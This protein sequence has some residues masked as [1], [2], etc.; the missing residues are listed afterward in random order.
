MNNSIEDIEYDI[1]TELK[2][3]EQ[4]WLIYSDNERVWGVEVSFD[5]DLKRKYTLITLDMKSKN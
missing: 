2:D 4:C 5:A 3:F 1:A